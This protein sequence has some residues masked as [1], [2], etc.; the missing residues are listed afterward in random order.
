MSINYFVEGY[1]RFCKVQ[2]LLVIICCIFNKDIL[3]FF[4]IMTVEA[5]W[6]FFQTPL[7]YIAECILIFV[8]KTAFETQSQIK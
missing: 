4:Y 5:R 7:A 1:T 8:F 6:F 3:L 2:V